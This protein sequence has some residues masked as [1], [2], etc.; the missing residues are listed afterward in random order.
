MWPTRR[1]RLPQT[2][3]RLATCAGNRCRRSDEEWRHKQK[4]GSHVGAFGSIFTP[5]ES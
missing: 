3:R 1:D 5:S 4:T 2:R